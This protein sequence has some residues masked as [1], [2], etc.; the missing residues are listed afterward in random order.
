MYRYTLSGPQLHAL[1]ALSLEKE[2]LLPSGM[3]AV[4]VSPR[5]VLDDKER[6]ECL[7]LPGFEIWPLGH[8]LW[9]HSIYRLSYRLPNDNLRV[10][11]L[12]L[13]FLHRQ[14]WRLFLCIVIA[15]VPPKRRLILIGLHCATLHKM[16]ISRIYRNC[17]SLKD[18]FNSSDSGMLSNYRTI[19]EQWLGKPWRDAVMVHFVT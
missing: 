6:W 19:S 9:S 5:S 4:R 8:P 7:S 18:V 10:F 17:C 16:V 3:E 15:F 14:L 11:R 13:S 12:S 1:A 2:H